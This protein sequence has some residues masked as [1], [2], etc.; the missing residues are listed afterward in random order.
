MVFEN[1]GI[2]MAVA[3]P[4]NVDTVTISGRKFI[5][6]GEAFYEWLGGLT[7]PGFLEYT[8][9]LKDPSVD[10]G[11]G[12]AT[13]ANVSNSKSLTKDGQV[14]RLQSPG[15]EIIRGY[16]FYIRKNERFYKFSNE[17]QLIK[18]IPSERQRISELVKSN[19]INFK[20]ASEVQQLIMQIN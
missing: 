17:Q 5:P 14:Y 6:V 4:E 18:V 19:K 7:Y 20:N 9:I 16:N 3:N 8:Y 15:L 11:F 1:A 13:T 12:K 2:Y 10:N